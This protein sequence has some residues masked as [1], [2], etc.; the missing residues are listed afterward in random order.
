MASSL[1]NFL[2]SEKHPYISLSY[3]ARVYQRASLLFAFAA[4]PVSLVF[5]ASVEKKLSRRQYALEKKRSLSLSLSFTTSLLLITG[6]KARERITERERER[7][8]CGSWNLE[9]SRALRP[10]NY[11]IRS[12]DCLRSSVSGIRWIVPLRLCILAKK[13]A[14][15]YI[16]T[17]IYLPR[18]RKI[19]N[20]VQSR[21]CSIHAMTPA[22]QPRQNPIFAVIFGAR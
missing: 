6:L 2:P 7:E 3:P 15:I 1:R 4:T 21:V 17:Y 14:C 5:C 8:L 22:A 11:K 10:V 13:H 16:Y 18:S 19:N 20:T 9:F 12:A